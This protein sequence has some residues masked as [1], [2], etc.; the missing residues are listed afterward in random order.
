MRTTAPSS[1][2]RDLSAS[3]GLRVRC[4]RPKTEYVAMNPGGVD[5]R[6]KYAGMG[7]IGDER[8]DTSRYRVHKSIDRNRECLF[9]VLAVHNR[10]SASVE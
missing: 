8:D 5:R 3:V 10:A 1:R 7:F 9:V 6:R 4:T 2:R